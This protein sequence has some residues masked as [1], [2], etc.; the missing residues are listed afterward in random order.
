VSQKGWIEVFRGP[1]LQGEIV[2]SALAAAGLEVSELGGMPTYAGLDFDDYRLYV[3][4]EQAE[5][6][7][8]LIAEAESGP[9]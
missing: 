6:A 8:K 2:A 9:A 4:E 5:A 7:R 1:R 3:P